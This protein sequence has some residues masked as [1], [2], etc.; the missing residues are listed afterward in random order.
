MDT[1]HYDRIRVELD[2]E[3]PV[4]GPYSADAATAASQLNAENIVEVGELRATELTILEAFA[5]P[6]SGEAFLAKLDAAAN[7]NSLLKRT[8]KWMQPGDGGIDLGHATVRSQLDQ[9]AAA[10]VITGPERDTVKALAEVKTSRASQLG[11]GRVRTGHV[12]KAR[13]V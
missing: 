7:S 9:L 13:A 1:A 12:E 11:F 5:D 10:N 4:T 8:L 3:H 2:A 6:F